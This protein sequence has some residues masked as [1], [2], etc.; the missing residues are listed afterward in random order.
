VAK[1]ALIHKPQ[2][3]LML[4]E[5]AN[6]TVFLQWLILLKPEKLSGHAEVDA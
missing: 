4:K 6:S 1:S 2:L 3:A 5:Q